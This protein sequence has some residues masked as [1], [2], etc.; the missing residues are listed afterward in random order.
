MTE[1]RRSGG[2]LRGAVASWR[3]S[4]LA[5][6]G[7]SF[8]INVLMLTA[9]L[10]MMQVYDRVLASRSDSTLVAITALAGAL[11]LVMGVLDWVL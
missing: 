9:P 2:E 8:C 11:L 5:T 7:F 1:N 4:W 6:A 3:G 10:Y